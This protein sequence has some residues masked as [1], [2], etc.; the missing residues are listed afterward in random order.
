MPTPAE[1]AQILALPTYT[2]PQFIYRGYTI[3]V[4]AKWYNSVREMLV[5]DFTSTK[6][7]VP[8]DLN[9]P[10]RYY[11]P[12][13]GKYDVDGVTVIS[14]PAAALIGMFKSTL[15]EQIDAVEG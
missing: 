6:D 1:K 12:P 4:T 8:V 9:Q 2:I 13:T 5:I 3:T 10:Y 14:A 15:D 7:G 11:N